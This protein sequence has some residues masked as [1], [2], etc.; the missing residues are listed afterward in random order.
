M[1]STCCS[2]SPR[3]AFVSFHACSSSALHGRTFVQLALVLFALLPAI[4]FGCD[5]RA[6]SDAVSS[7]AR[8]KHIP[9]MAIAVSDE[10][11][12]LWS[13]GYGVANLEDNVPVS[14][15][16]TR[17]RIGSTS[18]ALTAFGLMRLV[19][20]GQFDIDAPIKQYVP[21]VTDLGITARLLGGHLAGIRGY[22]DISEL[23]STTHYPS[24]TASLSVFMQDPLV[25]P[26]G[27]QFVYSSY[28]FTLLSAAI[29]TAA[30]E[31][32]LT[33]MSKEVFTPL[34]M[35]STVPDEPTA[36]V[37]GRTGFY[38]FD[39]GELKNGPPID[40]S[41]KWA[42]A[43]FLSTA[44]D[45]ARFGRA[46]FDTPL[47]SERSQQILWRSQRTE[48]GVATNY[49]LG[50]FIHDGYVEHPG[51]IVG[52]SALL[53][54]Y[55]QEKLVIAILG[56]LSI[57]ADDWAGDLPDKFHSCFSIRRSPATPPSPT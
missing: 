51:G 46:N 40:S 39:A 11:R 41:Y 7:V 54:I 35:S 43:G 49:G 56:N 37:S 28:G 42:G 47:L 30:K 2:Q 1:R 8:S 6:L 15:E 18:K 9:G 29:E 13:F 36:I 22:R 55:P 17:F 16:H 20:R 19:D 12:V 5:E 52:G 4:G 14:P 44:L 48:A 24:V 3:G 32:F 33:Y 45:L 27:E 53:R 26:P 21:S 31:D 38:Y 50:W 57:V 10:S 34:H 25:A 23:G